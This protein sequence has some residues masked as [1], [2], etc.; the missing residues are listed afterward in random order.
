MKMWHR[1]SS[2]LS[3][4][5]CQILQFWVNSWILIEFL[6]KIA[7]VEENQVLDELADFN[8]V[9][10]DHTEAASSSM[11]SSS[12]AISSQYS[13]NCSSESDDIEWTLTTSTGR[14]TRA[15]AS[16]SQTVTQQRRTR[17]RS[18]K[19]EDRRIRKKEQNKTAAT[20]Y[21]IKKKAELEILLEEEAELEQQNQQ[22]Q[23]RHEDLANE[24]RYLKKLMRELFTSR[25][26]KRLWF[27][28]SY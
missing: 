24:V 3:W 21:R 9:L 10:M 22:L 28:N 6:F 27:F 2:I 15:V 7:D 14:K 4:K 5:V 17:K 18:L 11:A 20:R 25:S 19:T 26:V 13:S 12:T 23:K 8:L 16:L 1:L